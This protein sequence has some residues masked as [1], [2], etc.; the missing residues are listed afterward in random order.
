VITMLR[1]QL[2]IH[3]TIAR[4]PRQWFGHATVCCVAVAS[5]VA[6]MV[7][8]RFSIFSRSPKVVQMP[9]TKP[10][11]PQTHTRG[12]PRPITRSSQESSW[13]SGA[14][15]TL[16]AAAAC[17]M[18]KFSLLLLLFFGY[19]RPIPRSPPSN[20]HKVHKNKDCTCKFF[21]D[22]VSKRVS[23]PIAMQ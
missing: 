8:T 12:P 1:E 21:I 7:S 9:I 14:R 2:H 20:H 3:Y 22:W 10:P 23:C 15:A 17:A 16:H 19:R 11:A 6:C 18:M 4:P 5:P 13:V